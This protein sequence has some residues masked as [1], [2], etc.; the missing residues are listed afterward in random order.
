MTP[1]SDTNE[2]NHL[3]DCR[4][5]LNTYQGALHVR[6]GRLLRVAVYAANRNC[7]ELR[8]DRHASALA[9]CFPAAVALLDG[10]Y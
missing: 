7:A 5:L 10:K 1:A 9:R 3:R 6:S 8:Y 4:I 2:L